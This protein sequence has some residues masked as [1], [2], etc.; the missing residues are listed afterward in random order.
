MQGIPTDIRRRVA[1]L[2]LFDTCTLRCGYC[3][4]AES[5]NV[6]DFSQLDRFR[7]PNILDKIVSFFLSRTTPNLPWLLILTGGEPLLAP[8]LDRLMTPLL[9]AGNRMAYYTALMVGHNHPGFRFLLD[10]PF[11][12]TDYVMASLHP[13][14]ELEEPRYFDKIR[15][16]KEAG[17]RVFVRFV[18]HPKRLHRLSELSERCR[19]LDVCFYPTTLLSN[20]YPASYTTAEKTQLQSHFSSLSQFIQLEG[21]LDTNGLMCHGGSGVISVNLQTGNITPC[22]TVHSPSLGNI[23][24]D[25]LQWFDGPALCPEPGITCVCDIHF[26]QNIVLSAGDQTRF[27]Q[28]SRGFVPP[29]DYSTELSEMS[30]QFYNKTRTGMGDV[31]D[32]GQ[33]F[34]TIEEVR[35]NYRTAR[36]LPRTSLNRP[37][38]LELGSALQNV[39]LCDERAE[40]RSGSPMTILTPPAQ[41]SWA[42]AIPLIFPQEIPG[43]FWLRI[44]ATVSQGEAGFGILNKEG[45][46][47]QDRCFLPAGP[48]RRTV[49]LQVSNPPNAS[50]LIIENSAAGGTPAGILL[51]T[52]TVFVAQP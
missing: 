13:E 52:V 33:L 32:D 44:R 14:S 1:E 7:D 19:D 5:G 9:D 34:Y 28:L 49:F 51:D 6:L 15:M 39:Q 11:P 22:I 18:S 24:E 4:L 50:S 17:H 45:T 20:H 41:W 27:E 47:F 43:E 29:Q 48:E 10:H 26:Q 23:F 40:I 31:A 12:E 25:R 16:L 8:N 30:L 38:L 21:G 42:A 37:H 2:Y 35:E 46:S 3:W 36:S